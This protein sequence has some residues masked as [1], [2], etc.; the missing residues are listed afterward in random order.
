M[1]RAERIM[2]AILITATE[3]VVLAV[4]VILGFI[5]A[6]NAAEV[7]IAGYRPTPSERRLGYVQVAVASLLPTVGPLCVWI[8]LR[9]KTALIVGAWLFSLSALGWLFLAAT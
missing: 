2:F 7:S 8:K 4:S 6:M 3:L 9:S 5:G 1:T